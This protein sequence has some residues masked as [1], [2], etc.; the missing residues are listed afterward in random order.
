MRYIDR[1]GCKKLADRGQDMDINSLGALS[2]AATKNAEDNRLAVLKTHWGK[3]KIIKDSGLGA[4]S[5]VFDTLAEVDAFL[6]DLDA[7]ENERY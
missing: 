1:T 5:T 6:K 3:Y 2:R 4:Y 7:H